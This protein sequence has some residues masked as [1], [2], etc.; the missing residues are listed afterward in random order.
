MRGR[1]VQRNKNKGNAETI[2]KT[3]STGRGQRGVR[4]AGA[5]SSVARL[6]HLTTDHAPLR[7]GAPFRLLVERLL[8]HLDALTFFT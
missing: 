6:R 4:G 7:D 1:G 5:Y 2:R 3:R 8:E